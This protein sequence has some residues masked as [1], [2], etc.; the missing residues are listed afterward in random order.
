MQS[1]GSRVVPGRVVRETESR[2]DVWI[3]AVVD[4]D[5]RRLD[6]VFDALAVRDSSQ[7]ALNFAGT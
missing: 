6:I 4:R 7:E 2:A 5:G 1:S 3:G